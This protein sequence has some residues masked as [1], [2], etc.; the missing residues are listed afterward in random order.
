MYEVFEVVKANQETV[1]FGFLIAC[2]RLQNFMAIKHLFQ[3]Q[4]CAD[5]RETYMYI[6]QTF[7]W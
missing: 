3:F 6:I 4:D 2:R 1:D 5:V 7:T